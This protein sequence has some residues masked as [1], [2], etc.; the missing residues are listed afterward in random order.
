MERKSPLKTPKGL[1]SE[2]LLHVADNL[3]SDDIAKFR[4]VFRD[5]IPAQ[6]L[7]GNNP[8]IWFEQ[9][10]RRGK[11]SMNDLGCLEDFLKQ[12]SLIKLLDDVKVYRIKQN[13]VRA[14]LEQIQHRSKGRLGM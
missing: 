11:I 3:T 14:L 9:L 6:I 13:L 5:E 4:F 12:A 8:L 2:I 10:E 1:F 7:E